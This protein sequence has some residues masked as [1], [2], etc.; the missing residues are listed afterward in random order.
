MLIIYKY[1]FIN[2]R[3]I[4][5]LFMVNL[6]AYTSLAQNEFRA[7]IKD[8]ETEELLPGATAII[9]S[10]GNGA[11]ADINGLTEIHNIPNGL[12]LITF[13]ML[14]YQTAVYKFWFPFL[15]DSINIIL[16][17]NESE[18]LDEVQV[19]ATRSSRVI[20]DIPTRIETITAGELAEKATMQ[21]ANIKMILTESTGIQTQQTSAISANTS[22]RIQGLDGKYTQLLKDGFP[23]YSGFSGG[24]SLLQIPPLDLKRAEVIKG[25]SSTLYG[26]GA[27]AG[28]I[29]LVT[30][31]P[32]DKDEFTSM[33]N[34]TSAK[35]FD[36]NTFYSHKFNKTGITVFLARN[37]QAAY[38]PDNDNL[39]DLPK[40][41]IYNFNPKVFYYINPTTIISLGLISSVENRLGGDMVLISNKTDS[42]HTFY[43]LN[44]S[45]RN[46][47]LFKFEKSFRN[48]TVLTFKNS[49]AYFSRNIEM[50]LYHFGGKQISGFAEINYH[51]TGEKSEWI[52]GL[53]EWT[54]SFSEIRTSF[55]LNRNYRQVTLGAFLQNNLKITDRFITESGI[56]ADYLTLKSPYYR[57]KS[58]TVILPHL[59]MM[60]KFTS[61]LTSRLGGGLGYKAP[62]IFD[63]EAE[64]Q[65]FRN[66]MPINLNKSKPE[67]SVGINVD[68]NYKKT[69]FNRLSI[70]INQLF[71][72]TRINEPLVANSAMLAHDTLDYE[73]I[74][75]NICSKG[76]ETNIKLRFDHYSV[77]IGY[78][79]INAEKNYNS[80]TTRNLLTAHHR[81]YFTPMYEI[82]NKI[83]IGFEV[84]YVS[85]QL[86][87]SGETSRAYWLMGFSVE[88][89]FKHFSLFLN[90][91]NIPDSRQSRWQ[92]MYSGS[93][94]NPRFAEIWAP[95]DGFI[96]N[97]GIRL[98]L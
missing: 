65:G 67:K 50:P 77:Y 31:E 45:F 97:G 68:I 48:K 92:P 64:K 22:I 93:M 98:L 44:K 90:L 83:R 39:S 37:S 17:E 74:I 51:V 7:V 11:V 58:Y 43:Q 57:D 59:S 72:Y 5:M 55:F 94:Q 15:A 53:N 85:P 89:Y 73:N 88:K 61:N 71:F 82:E 30:K 47:I 75:G 25:S 60:F 96:F 80:I 14:G 13:S 56:R 24:L 2:M 23:L 63:E 33:V 86:L 4:F 46:T 32:T 28:L 38:D 3:Y 54:D 10:I 66:V 87:S 49:I 81:L 52:A 78:T 1:Y 40:N 35:G 84:F 19:T 29:N 6:F 69:L 79:F 8:K 34:M 91:E 42:A 41:V 12:H 76:L 26:G 9:K 18:E 62:G 20:S 27:I 36:L 16:L 70:S 95:T 21:S